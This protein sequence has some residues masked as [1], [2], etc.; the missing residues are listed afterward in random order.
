MI[1]TKNYDLKM[2]IL[3]IFLKLQYFK[4]IIGRAISAMRVSVLKKD[5]ETDYYIAGM[6]REDSFSY[7]KSL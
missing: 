3:K 4:I 7:G 5:T 2:C 6:S 1:K